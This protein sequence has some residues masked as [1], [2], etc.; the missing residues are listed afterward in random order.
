MFESVA[1]CLREEFNLLLLWSLFFLPCDRTEAEVGGLSSLV[2][3]PSPHPALPGE[4]D[5]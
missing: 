4:S 1:V 2:L 3:A 5:L